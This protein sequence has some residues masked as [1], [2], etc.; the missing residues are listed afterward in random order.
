MGN[1]SCRFFIMKKRSS[2]FTTIKSSDFKHKCIHD[3]QGNCLLLNRI[4]TTKTCPQYLHADIHQLSSKDISNVR[5]ALLNIQGGDCK[6]CSK[7]IRAG[8]ACLDHHHQK[9]NK[10]T[11][12]I[13]GVLCRTCNTLL[14]KMENN[15][16]RYRISNEE[17]PMVLVAMSAYLKDTQLPYLHPSEKPRI[18]KLQLASYKKLQKAFIRSRNPKKFPE[19]PKSGTVTKE[20][21]K[22]FTQYKIVPVFY[23]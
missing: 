21:D 20:L 2:F 6:I 14:A 23:K 3:T 19:Y 7:K 4:C 15:A 12:Q 5:T 8:E 16:V 1:S 9:K 17:L 10:G 18:K 13:R 11:G 22:L